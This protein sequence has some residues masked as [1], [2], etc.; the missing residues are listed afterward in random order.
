[1]VAEVIGVTVKL[2]AKAHRATFL[3]IVL[4]S[5]RLPL[6]PVVHMEDANSSANTC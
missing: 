3:A 2:V 4:V 1:M 6:V 5:S